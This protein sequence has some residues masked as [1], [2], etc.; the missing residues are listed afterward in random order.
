MLRLS[1]VLGAIIILG[2]IVFFNNKD[3]ESDRGDGGA[4]VA[5]G[6]ETFDPGAFELDTDGDGLRDWEESLWGTDLNNPDTDGDGTPDGEEVRLGRDPLIPGPNDKIDTSTI[7]AYARTDT[8]N[9]TVTESFERDFYNGLAQLSSDNQLSDETLQTFIMGLAR[10][11]VVRERIDL[12]YTESDISISPDPS[13]A[14]AKDYVNRLGVAANI[15]QGI[16]LQRELGEIQAFVGSQNPAT[17]AALDA[18]IAEYKNAREAV[19]GVGTVPFAFSESYLTILN[20]I[21]SI[22]KALSE[23]REYAVSDPLKGMIR[24]SLYQ[25]GVVL[26]TQGDL[27]T[28]SLITQ[29]NITFSP[30][31]PGFIFLNQ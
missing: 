8:E 14:A 12:D 11:Y 18:L 31:E 26:M 27:E 19:L 2:L 22:E 9:L 20:G 10:E 16:D 13:L 5:S 3:N 21:S 1:V 25:M 24:L 28:A 17:T 6:A 29:R 7:P 23:L 30:S 15:Y 4:V